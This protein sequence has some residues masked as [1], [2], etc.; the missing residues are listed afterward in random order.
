MATTHSFTKGEEI[1][2]AITH[3]FGALFSIVALV[4][5]PLLSSLHGSALHVIS[6]TIYG[7]TMLLLYFSSTM[8]HA[9][10]PGKAKDLFEIFDHASIYLFIAGS[11]TPLLFIVVQ[12][13]LGWTLF[14]IVWGIATIGVILKFFFVKRFLFLSTIFYIGMGW[15]ALFAIKPIMETLPQLGVALLFSG[16]ISYTVGTVFYM[17]RGFKYHHAIWHLFVLVGT[18][19]HFFL[20]LFYVLPMT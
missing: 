12:G 14:G 7:V 11:Y 2:N 15:L 9:L 10:P 16:G 18:I 19:L 17:W 5:L 1:A 4:I 6:F 20:I 13:T 8:V 3:G